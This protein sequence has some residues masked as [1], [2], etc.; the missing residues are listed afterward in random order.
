MGSMYDIANHHCQHVQGHTASWPA[1]SS[2]YSITVASMYHSIQHHG[3][4]VQQHTASWPARIEHMVS[5]PACTRAHRVM[6]ACT[7]T[8]SVMTST[9]KIAQQLLGWE[10]VLLSIYVQQFLYNFRSLLNAILLTT[11]TVQ[12]SSSTVHN[13]HIIKNNHHLH[14]DINRH[15]EAHRCST[16]LSN[17]CKTL[18]LSSLCYNFVE[19]QL[20]NLHG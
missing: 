3:Q 15:G 17:A 5:W 10:T 18:K 14:T 12:T 19:F 20:W 8:H 13:F 4:Q 16:T 9:Y 6:P 2:V 7:R 11:V 1:R